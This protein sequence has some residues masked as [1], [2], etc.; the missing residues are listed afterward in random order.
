MADVKTVARPSEDQL[1]VR[2]AS[3]VLGPDSV[4]LDS[5]GRVQFKD[6]KI[7]QAILSAAPTKL[8]AQDTNYA[9]CGGNGYCPKALTDQTQ[10]E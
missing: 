8:S 1:V 2:A 9:L 5:A 3:I 7:L 10:R 4:T 6:A